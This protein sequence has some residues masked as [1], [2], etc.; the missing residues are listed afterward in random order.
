[1]RRKKEKES[2]RGWGC[3]RRVEEWRNKNDHFLSLMKELSFLVNLNLHSLSGIIENNWK[4]ID[5][6]KL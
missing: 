3:V 6:N 4:I 5:T 2:G 1:M